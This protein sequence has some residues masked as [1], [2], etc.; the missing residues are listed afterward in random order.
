MVYSPF[1]YMHTKKVLK[2]DCLRSLQESV[3]ASM[4]AYDGRHPSATW[5]RRCR[6][7][8]RGTWRAL[9]WRRGCAWRWG[10]SRC[11]WMRRGWA[12]TCT[13]TSPHSAWR[14][15]KRRRKLSLKHWERH[16]C[17]WGHNVKIQGNTRSLR[18]RHD[19]T[20]GNN[21]SYVDV[22]SNHGET[23]QSLMTLWQNA[24]K[25]RI[26]KWRNVKTQGSI[27]C[28]WGR[29]FKTRKH[30]ESLMT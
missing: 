14:S 18:S 16:Q 19:K 4:R 11:W 7:R 1:K 28:L 21:W 3:T 15:R 25:H 29:Y 24:Q 22:R 6:Q 8:P 23:H 5:F 26:F 27:R 10:W 17:L 9:R 20:Q 12:R 2:C 30:T 13:R